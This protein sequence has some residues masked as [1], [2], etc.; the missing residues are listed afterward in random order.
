M[1]NRGSQPAI[2]TMRA[3]EEVK[4]F[5]SH[6]AIHTHTGK[7]FPPKWTA[8]LGLAQV[9]H[10]RRVVTGRPAEPVALTIRV[11]VSKRT[12]INQQRLP[13][14]SQLH[15]QRIGMAVAPPACSVRAGINHELKCQ[16]IRTGHHVDSAVLQRK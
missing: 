15:A 8:R 7:G 9:V 16:R 6:P 5:A 1:S 10:L 13:V 4:G 11:D 2:A 14:D 3:D 12:W